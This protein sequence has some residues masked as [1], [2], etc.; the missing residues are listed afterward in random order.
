MGK[1]KKNIEKFCVLSDDEEKCVFKV[2]SEDYK[3]YKEDEQSFCD[4]KQNNIGNCGVIAAFASMSK[5]PDFSNIFSF[6]NTDLATEFKVKKLSLNVFSQGKPE[7]ITIDNTLPFIKNTSTL[8]YAQSHLH[9][10]VLKAPLLEKAFV[11]IACNNSY[12]LC[13]G[14]DPAFVFCRFSGDVIDVRVWKTDESKE[15]VMDVSI[16]PGFENNPSVLSVSPSLNEVSCIEKFSGHVYAA[17]EYN[18]E[19]KALKIYE[20]N[21]S[22]D[23][24]KSNKSLPQELIDTA[25]PNHGELWITAEDLENRYVKIT[26]LCSNEYYKQTCIF[27]GKENIKLNQKVISRTVF[28]IEVKKK[29]QFIFNFFSNIFTES[30]LEIHF[31]H[32]N[33][34]SSVQIT[35]FTDYKLKQHDNSISNIEERFFSLIKCTLEPNVYVLQVCREL[36]DENLNNDGDEPSLFVEEERFHF[37]IACNREFELF[38]LT[39]KV[40]VDDEHEEVEEGDEFEDVE[41]DDE[42]EEVK[43]DD[44][45][46]L[47]NLKSQLETISISNVVESD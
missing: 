26:S 2:S 31:I 9:S 1:K 38:Y 47:T 35:N 6:E 39:K 21:C 32:K 27:Q 12:K 45:L 24:C 3:Y 23:W 22:P 10:N 18:E 44:D 14:R 13:D 40:K 30:P 43:V 42:H 28:K 20:P 29:S 19:Q 41:E 7:K 36:A 25:D 11:K 16:D 33:E 46:D 17:M 8:L 37:R 4:Y 15:T 34:D 5:H